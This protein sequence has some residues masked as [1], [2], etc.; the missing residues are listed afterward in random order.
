M[1]LFAVHSDVLF[2]AIRI[3]LNTSLIQVNSKS[4]EIR[5][6]AKKDGSILNDRML[7]RSSGNYACFVIGK[8]GA[9]ISTCT[10]SILTEISPFSH[11]VSHKI[12][13]IILFGTEFL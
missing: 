4:K 9:Q 7:Q 1:S 6:Q 8:P 13:I 2:Y 12:N 3:F 10:P 5:S 11:Y